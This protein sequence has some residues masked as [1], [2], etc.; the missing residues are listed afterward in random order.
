MSFENHEVLG[1][2]LEVIS[3][4]IRFFELMRFYI[5]KSEHYAPPVRSQ[6]RVSTSLTCFYSGII[7]SHTHGKK[8]V[9]KNDTEISSR[10]GDAPGRKVRRNV[11]YLFSFWRQFRMFIVVHK[12]Y[13][14][15]SEAQL[16]FNSLPL[17][18]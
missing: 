5:I 8:R 12:K 1:T 2:L 16:M 18:F 14:N 6:R 17:N 4:L 10:C 11:T 13:G 3:I 15:T 7:S 9:R